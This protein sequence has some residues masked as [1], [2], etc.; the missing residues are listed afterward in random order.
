MKQ[1]KADVNTPQK[2]QADVYSCSICNQNAKK[3]LEINERSA[4][5]H[6]GGFGF[7]THKGAQQ[8]PTT[9]NNNQTHRNFRCHSIEVQQA[10]ENDRNE[11]LDILEE[12]PAIDISQFPGED[13]LFQ[14]YPDFQHY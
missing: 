10:I 4:G 14:E 8:A 6:T 5:P 9:A 13:F 2:S 7:C 1:E 12:I 11:L 3:S